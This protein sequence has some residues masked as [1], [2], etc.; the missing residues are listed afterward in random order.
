MIIWRLYINECIKTFSKWRTYIGFAAI[1]LVVPL[2]MWGFSLGGSEI[3]RSMLEG[4]KDDFLMTGNLANGMW[5]SYALMFALF[6]H[7]PFL[8][9]LGAGDAVAGEGSAGTFRIYLTR[10]VSRNQILAAK[11]AAAATYS[12][13]LVLWMGFLSLTIG[14][15]WLGI[16]DVLI[17]DS[18]GILILPWDVAL[19]RFALA[20]LFASFMMFTVT[21]LTFMLSVLVTNAI[22]PIIGTMAILIIATV[23]S[24]LEIDSLSWLQTNLITYHFRVWQYAFFD[25]ILWDMVWESLINLGIYATIFTV[26]SFIFFHRKDI[27]S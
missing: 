26:L 21:T 15:L 8:I 20:Y 5:A 25:P 4:F 6:V 2:V 14:N 13:G 16:V 7:I 11:L 12:T 9:T 18:A 10:P 1:G 3:Q 17:L 24:V 22:G 27:L 19:I 23:L